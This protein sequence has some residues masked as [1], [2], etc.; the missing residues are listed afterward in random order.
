MLPVGTEGLCFDRTRDFGT[1]PPP[2][3]TPHKLEDKNAPAVASATS[4]PLPRN[5]CS[6]TVVGTT[7]VLLNFCTLPSSSDT[8]TSPPVT[9]ER[10][11]EREREREERERETERDRGGVRWGRV[12]EG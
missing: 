2:P 1:S 6:T 8:K 10:E 5:E 9:I 4:G 12:G 11:R 7:L 3:F